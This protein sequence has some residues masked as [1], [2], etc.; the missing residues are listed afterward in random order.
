MMFEIALRIIGVVVCVVI[1]IVCGWAAY[2]L[3]TDKE[4]GPGAVFAALVAFGMSVA[5]LVC[6]AACAFHGG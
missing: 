1:G 4:S 5:A 6:A 3:A 2:V